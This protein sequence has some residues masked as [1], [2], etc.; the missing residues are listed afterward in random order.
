MQETLPVVHDAR[1]FL[2]SKGIENNLENNVLWGLRTEVKLGM[3]TQVASTIH[4]QCFI[5]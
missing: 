3:G 5:S 1:K 2:K 4:S